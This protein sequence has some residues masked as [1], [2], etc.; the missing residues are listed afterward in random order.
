MSAESLS[1]FR[2]SQYHLKYSHRGQF[3]DWQ[4]NASLGVKEMFVRD[5]HGLERLDPCLAG[6]F[7]QTIS[8]R[9][10]FRQVGMGKFR[11]LDRVGE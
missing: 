7:T 11:I 4:S 5:E 10:V 9:N 6:E 2:L 3:K 8:P 1:K